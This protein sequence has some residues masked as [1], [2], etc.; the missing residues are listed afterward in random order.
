MGAAAGD[1]SG[2]S[3]SSAGDVNGDGVGDVI[4]GAYNVDLPSKA[5]AGVSYVL[6]GRNFSA[7]VSNPFADIQLTTGSTAMSPSIGF[8][9]LG[10]AAGDQCGIS[11]S[12][13]GD[14]NGD[15]VDDIIV[16]ALEADPPSGSR[17]GVSYVIFG[18]DIPGGATPFGD[19]QLTTGA[20]P[21]PGSIG[22]RMLGAAVNDLSG[23]A[24]S[25][26]GDVNNDGIGDIIVGARF[27]DP[28][29]GTDAGIS[30]IIFGR[31]IPGGD[32]PFGDI[33]L[34]SG[35]TALA[36]GIGVR[37]LG[38]ATGD[39]LGFSIS[40]A[41]DVNG[42]GIDD[43]IFGAYWADLPSKSDAGVTHV[44]YGRTQ[45]I[46]FVGD[47]QLTAGA[48][49]L[50]P[51]VGFRMLGAAA[52]DL[53]GYAVSAAGDVNNDGIG[54]IIIGAV[55]ADSPRGGNAGI[56]YVVFGR[57]LSAPNAVAFGDI[58]LTTGSTV[59]PSAIGFR[60]LGAASNDECGRSVVVLET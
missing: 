23:Y 15:G 53:S 55:Y 39:N 26:A 34:T 56:V 8:R 27:A 47:I 30:Y 51:A 19:I 48:I 36:A 28:P 16:G 41:G 33:Q 2:W 14:V 1:G 59:M 3:V 17:A 32:T 18:R 12:D 5:N 7:Q 31:N 9:I 60:I 54:D 10:A 37:I 57:N 49:A 38:A 13:A 44:L 24:V 58:Q 50:S 52:S 42:D 4:I 46:G 29:G 6:F 35:T 40:N 43:I 20:T 45:S 11:V 25:A 21:L 22:F